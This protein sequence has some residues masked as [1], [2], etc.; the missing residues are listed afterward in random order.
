MS[1]FANQFNKAIS[2]KNP[3]TQSLFSLDDVLGAKQ[4]DNAGSAF[5]TQMPGMPD[6]NNPSWLSKIAGSGT[7]QDPN[8]LTWGEGIFGGI[9]KDGSKVGG[10]AGPMFDL[11]KTGLNAYL[12]FKQLGTAEDT[13]AFQKD[14]FSK[15]FANQS[16]LINAQLRDRQQ[17]RLNRNPNNMSVDEYMK[18]NGV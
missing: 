7:I 6:I 10:L 14:A 3:N 4:A 18:L 16:T 13:L 15:Q 2:F 11:A 5:G 1:V 8:N 9:N 17:A 12:G